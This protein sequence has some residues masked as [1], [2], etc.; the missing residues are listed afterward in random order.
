M[1]TSA[2]GLG[3]ARDFDTS[4]VDAG[5]VGNGGA[6]HWRPRPG[7]PPALSCQHLSKTFAG[8]RALDD[9]AFDVAQGEVHGLLGTNG[10]G[11]STLI[12]VLAGF[13]APDPGSTL[14][15]GGYAVALPMAPGAARKHGLRFV[16][17]HLGLIASLSVVENMLLPDMADDRRLRIDWRSERAAC[18]AAMARYGIT[19]IDPRSPVSDLSPVDRALLA[20]VRAVAQMPG[21]DGAAPV[22]TDGKSGPGGVL[23]LDEPTPFLPREDVERLFDVVRRVAS[24]GAAVIFV[25]HDVD[26][27]REIT[28]RCTILRDGKRVDT[29]TTANTSKA[30]FIE[31]I[32]GRK[33]AAHQRAPLE[34]EGRTPDLQVGNLSGDGV[35]EIDIALH[36]GEVVGLTG[37]VGSGYAAVPYLI[38]G[39]QKADSGHIAFKPNAATSAS[40]SGSPP[41]AS[42]PAFDLTRQTPA[43]AIAQRFVL[44][45]G[46]RAHA[47]AIGSLPIVDNA[48]MPLLGNR[49][50]AWR[51]ARRAM[52]R[53]AG[54]LG[55]RFD[56]M[57]N[58]P[59][60]PMQALSGGNQQKVVL[61][62]W[63][64]T[65]PDLVLL[66]EPTQ[67]VDVGARA[68]VF[69][70]IQAATDS[71][72]MVL[73]AS[74]DY[75]QFEQIADRVLI[76]AQGRIVA[77]LQGA[78][79]TKS[80][81][82]ECCY[83]HSGST[84]VPTVTAQPAPMDTR[85]P[86]PSKETA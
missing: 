70:Q 38:Y 17:Q 65:A 71:G 21:Q 40:I 26:E 60:L 7:D 78:E 81:I 3:P 29:L 10:S 52:V 61:A 35:H 36:R 83:A 45:P 77:S 53:L 75:E 11:K 55:Q 2:S 25:S 20:I 13:H 84:S 5:G 57:P 58:K 24:A 16:H 34:A 43:H 44:I 74:S 50:H 64:Q 27:V 4:K 32:I 28:H 73:C 47:A 86:L 66:D 85:Y 41:S 31:R 79:I 37:L 69:Q 62:K 56:L 12:K 9:V 6:A 46:D 8:Q 59:L 76:F 82:A 30:D 63:L 33:V 23:V 49:F 51:L 14:T 1:S 19:S 67:G 18:A 80:A 54:D 22:P 72:A 15:M 68:A 42:I 39:A 48:T